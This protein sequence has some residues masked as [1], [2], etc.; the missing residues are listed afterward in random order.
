MLKKMYNTEVEYVKLF[1]QSYE[2]NN[3]IRF[4]DDYIPDMY[5]HNFV[6]IKKI[7]E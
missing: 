7:R 5:T 2:S 6:F 1:S 4:G 3:I